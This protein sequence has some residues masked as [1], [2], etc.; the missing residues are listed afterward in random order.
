MGSLVRRITS[1]AQAGYGVNILEVAPPASVSGVSSNIAGI[2]AHLPWGPVNEVTEISS[3][4]EFF[5]VF[6]P[7][8]FT[9]DETTF[10]ALYAFM[11]KSF[12]GGMK[13]VRIATGTQATAARTF[14]D[15]SAGDSVTVTA[16]YGGTAGN[17]IYITWTANADDATARDA[18]VTIGTTYTKTY[19][20]VATIVSSALVVTDPGD[21]YVT[22]TKASGAT[23]VPAA[24]A[25]TALTGGVDGTPTSSNYLGS[26]S[27]SVGLRL[28]YGDSIDVNVVFVAE[29]DESLID[30]INDGLVTFADETKKAVVVLNTVEGQAYAD[31]KT[32]VADY[33]QSDGYVVYPWPKV[34]TVN[35]YDDDRGEILV[36][37]NSFIASAL[38][39]IDP[40]VSVAGKLGSQALYGI[41]DLEFT[42]TTKGQ[43]DQLKAKGILSFFMSTAR[44]G[45]VTIGDPNTSLESGKGKIFRRRMTD[46]ITVSISNLLEL[47]I[48]ETLDVNLTTG[49]LGPTTTAE[50]SAIA[51]FLDNLVSDGRIQDYMVDGL[52]GNLQANLDDGEWIILLQVKLNPHQE[53]II[54]KA[55]IGE[56][57]TITEA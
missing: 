3:P 1:A 46:Y 55:E 14:D 9:L 52:S 39:S 50:I 47:Y 25:A 24:I 19:E 20:Q 2:I 10:T 45:A 38:V 43:L 42:D 13:I 28:F 53:V 40:E 23:L 26:G 44:G 6:A 49:T 27:S 30:A 33:R 18:T 34:Y 8:V 7:T 21:P 5:S 51:G 11:N 37:G 35:T 57:V 31:A 17:Q 15:A 54:L 32:Y 16:N 29:P 22:F 48:G 12:S 41:T 56:T 4:T 36:N